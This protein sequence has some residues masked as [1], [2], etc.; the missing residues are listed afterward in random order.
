MR[1][2]IEKKMRL[3]EST[4]PA[5]VRRASKSKVVIG[6]NGNKAIAYEWKWMWDEVWSNREDGL[7]SKKVSDFDEALTCASCGRRIVH[8]YWVET[9]DGEILPYGGDH[10]HIALG[11]PREISKSKLERMKNEITSAKQRKIEDDHFKAKY[12]MYISS[13]S[14]P[15]IGSANLLFLKSKGK[16]GPKPVFLLNR[17]EN[18]VMRADDIAIDRF[19]SYFPHWKVEHPSKIREVLNA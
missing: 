2:L 6:P 5:W 15:D 18:A 11:Y 4:I 14:A 1:E 7:V 17:K 13:R 10:L 9:T 8:V 12:G 16:K 19:L 3:F